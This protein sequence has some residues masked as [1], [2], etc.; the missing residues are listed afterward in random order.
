MESPEGIVPRARTSRTLTIALIVAVAGLMAMPTAGVLGAPAAPVTTH[1]TLGTSGGANLAT[2]VVSAAAHTPL[3]RSSPSPNAH[4]N[5]PAIFSSAIRSLE[6][7]AGPARGVPQACIDTT[8]ITGHCGPAAPFSAGSRTGVIGPITGWQNA[9]AGSQ[10]YFGGP[11][12]AIAAS[13]A[14]DPFDGYVVYYGG[15]GAQICPENF[16]WVYSF[17]VWFNITNPADSPPAV[18]GASMTFDY[19]VNMVVLF[20]GCGVAACPMNETW[21]FQ[22]GTWTDVS[23]PFC[24]YVCFWAPSPRWGSTMV[25]ANNSVDN[26]TVLFGGC[27]DAFCYTA[28]NETYQWVGSLAA[29]VPYTLSVAPSPRG[30]AQAAYMPG[31]GLLLFGGCTP[32]YYFTCSLNDTWIFYNATWTDYSLYLQ[33]FGFQTPPGRAYSAMEYDTALG[34]VLMVGGYNDTTDLSDTWAWSCP[35]FCGWFNVS[36]VNDLPTP[37]WLMA[38]PTESGSYVPLLD[39][40]YCTCVGGGVQYNG[41]TWV[42]EPA[43]SDNAVVTPT[44]TPLRSAVSFNGN[45]SGGTAPYIGYW[46][47]G[48]GNFIGINATYNYTV[49]GTYTVQLIAWDLWGVSVYHSLTV[50]VTP[51]VSTAQAAPVSTDVGR[52]VSF[53]AS[54]PT[55]GSEPYNYSWSFGDGSS[56]WGSPAT[57]AFAATGTYQANVTVADV[58][59]VT[60]NSSVN[61][62]VHPAPAVS[63]GATPHATDAGVTVTFSS[64]PTGGVAPYTYA[65]KFGDG[66]TGSGAAPTHS[67]ASSGTFTVNVTLTDAVGVTANASVTVTINPALAASVTS[68]PSAPVTGATVYFNATASGGTPA[69][70]YAWTFGDGGSGTGAAA[71]HSYAN[72][73]SFT[74][75]LWVNDSVG[76]SVHKTVAVTVTKA[77][78]GGSTSSSSS[79]LPSWIWYVLVVVVILVVVGLAVMMMRRKRPGAPASSA[80]PT[81]ASGGA[82]PSGAAWSEG[83]PPATPPP[84]AQ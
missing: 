24:F 49:A 74:A 23:A 64:T 67:Y 66:G 70:T 3:F 32:G 45:L 65:W 34:E 72:A 62:T 19:T 47:T 22:S 16:T 84:G 80:P 58:H 61:V 48:D 39:G 13:M 18:Y 28:T 21:E 35:Y 25:F 73:G 29:W 9:T 55:G 10:F 1:R 59:N 5:G 52:T 4:A 43:V 76:V 17:G 12:P 82:P 57:H 6:A 69:Y 15:C 36:N 11:P 20:G 41:F 83:P 44:T 53:L 54:T 60:T 26:V 46:I 79:S 63:A 78:G 40:G 75:N 81:G 42:Y 8:G 68:A 37:E 56:G 14:W 2:T 33:V 27:L 31:N 7:G 71:T 50:T 38:M 30:F 51:L 77:G